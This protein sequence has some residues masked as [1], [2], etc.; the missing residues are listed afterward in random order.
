MNAVRDGMDRT[1][2]LYIAG[3]GRS[4]ST[5]LANILG[6]VEGVFCGGEIRYLWERGVRDDRLCGCGVPFSACPVWTAILAQAAPGRTER[7]AEALIA[8]AARGTRIRH[9]PLMLLP[10]GERAIRR[11]GALPDRTA[12]VYTA[13][14]QVTGA[15]LVVDSSKLPSYGYVLDRLPAVDL[16]VL[17]LVRDPRAAAFSW[18]RKKPLADGAAS[19]FMQQQSPFRSAVLWD[20]WNLTTAAFWHAS[21]DRYLR[22]RYEDLMGRPEASVQQILSFVGL[23]T[24]I[25][26]VFPDQHTARV[27]ISH[28]VAGNPDRLR[29]GDV[30]LRLDN[31]WETQMGRRD[32]AL[33]TAMTAPLLGRYCGTGARRS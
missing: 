6:S 13:I 20:V 5:L 23:S 30:R 32:R 11:L 22:L 28:T 19:A 15:S 16:F 9:L 12:Q 2:V 1:K 25:S 27:G 4:G 24:D 14:R 10:G 18:R 26:P 31:Q 33:V 8:D 17:H 3:S 21:P 29:G 7:E